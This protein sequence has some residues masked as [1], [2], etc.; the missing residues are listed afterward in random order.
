MLKVLLFPV[1]VLMPALSFALPIEFKGVDVMG[2]P[3][4]LK[5]AQSTKGT[6]ILFLSA[7]CPCSAS[8]ETGL[9]SLYQEY[10]KKGF[11]FLGVHSNADEPQELTR[12]H[13]GSIQL[14]FPVL[15]DENSTLANEFHAY[16]T[17]HAFVMDPSGKL[18]FQGGVD[19]SHNANESKRPYLR[20]A[21]VAISNHQTPDPAE[22]RALGCVIKRKNRK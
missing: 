10:S 19:D 1:L 18:L 6:V 12:A 14:P 3:I 2:K 16:K 7:K 22:V 15:S 13:F 4:V 17:P 9:V 21:L 20:M 8:H 5:A 11:Q